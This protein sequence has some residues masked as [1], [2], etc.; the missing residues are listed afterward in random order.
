MQRLAAHANRRCAPSGQPPRPF[1]STP[2]FTSLRRL[3][4]ELRHPED[5]LPW[6]LRE[7]LRPGPGAVEVPFLYQRWCGVKIVEMLWE[8]GWESGS[9]PVPALFLGGCI[10][11]AKG[12]AGEATGGAR[13]EISLW[14]EPHLT[15]PGRHASG[16]HSIA[17][18]A[19][20]DFVFVTPGPNGVDAFVLDPTMSTER[21][22][23]QEKSRYLSDLAFDGLHMVA[24]V[25]VLH[26]PRRAWAAAPIRASRCELHDLEG[27][28]G[29]VP[30]HPLE[31]AGRALR[32]WLDDVEAHARAWRRR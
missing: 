20:P 32:G 12:P 25:P 2:A 3:L 6:L 18:E 19:S 8:M 7:L 21:A 15:L 11:F 29:T 27:R 10:R 23:M 5:S 30:L 1:P 28:S 31:G 14:C 22:A 17:K 24:G 4:D 26:Q 16:L 13:C 9:D